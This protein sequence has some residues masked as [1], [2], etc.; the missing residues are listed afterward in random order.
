MRCVSAL[1][2]HGVVIEAVC[3]RI[4]EPAARVRVVRH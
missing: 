3:G 1:A 4:I 2:A